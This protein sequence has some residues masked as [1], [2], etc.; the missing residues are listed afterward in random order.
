[1]V[2]RANPV[3]LCVTGPEAEAHRD[4]EFIKDRIGSAADW[5]EI[6]CNGPCAAPAVQ[7]LDETFKQLMVMGGTG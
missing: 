5:D 2:G 3:S 1:M 6:L 4:R 7:P